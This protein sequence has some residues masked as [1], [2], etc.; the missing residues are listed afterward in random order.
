MV[1]FD[2]NTFF[3][4]EE[5]AENEIVE[6][7]VVDEDDENGTNLVRQAAQLL[8][9]DGDN[10]P[11]S[12]SVAGMEFESGEQFAALC[13][14]YA[15]KIEFQFQVRTSDIMDVYKEKGV[16]RNGV[17]ENEVQFHMMKRLRLICSRG[18]RCRANA[19]DPLCKV[20]VEGRIKFGV[21]KFVIMQ[22]QLE[23]NHEL[24]PSSSRHAVNYR[25]I[26][27]YF[28]RRMMLNDRAGIPITRNFNTIVMECGGYENIPFNDRD[29]K[30]A[31]NRERRKGRIGGD[32]QELINYFD[33]LKRD[34]A[35]FYF[36][37]QR[38]VNGALLNVF[39]ADARCRAMY[40]V[41]DDPVSYDTTFLSNRYRMP[42]SPFVGV[43]HH[44]CTIFFAAALVSYEDAET[45]E[46]VFERWVE[47]MGNAPNVFI[48]DQDKAM[49]VAIRKV[50]PETKHRLCLWHIL[51]NADKNLRNLPHFKSI[52]E[53]LRKMVHESLT[54]DEFQ[55]MWEQMVDK[56]SLQQNTWIKDAWHMRRR[57]V[58]VFWRG[59]FCAGM[60]STQRSEQSNR[61]IKSYVSVE[62]G[63]RQF[64]EQYEF[65]L[66]RKVEEE[67]KMNFNDKNKPLKWD[68]SILFEVVYHKEERRSFDVKIDTLIGDYACGC[69]KFEF[70]GIL[71]RHIMK[72]LA[73]LN[74][75]AIPDKY[76]LDRWRKDLVRGYENIRVG[77]YDP[78]ESERV[79]RSL[80][81]TMRN[82]YI[83]SLA[84]QDEEARAIYLEKTN[85]LIKSLE[86]HAGIETVDLF[87]E[88]AGS[89]RVWGHR[90]LQRKE[91]VGRPRQE[92]ADV[93]DP[94]DKRGNG[95]R[96]VP[97]QPKR[98]KESTTNAVPNPPLPHE[99]TSSQMS[100]FSTSQLRET[101]STPQM[102]GSQ[103][104][105]LL[106]TS[107]QTPQFS[108]SYFGHS[109]RMN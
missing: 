80:E 19:D 44:G 25:H 106:S 88:G 84:M 66:R 65:A 31:I 48:T 4:H 85:D 79:R 60:S 58:P 23:H 75:K 12:A 107:Q 101:Q 15:Y 47:C 78:I 33:T 30:N 3:D 37:Y 50:F 13:F 10:E 9:G 76:I 103:R 52:D 6:E 49:E 26:G 5:E 18:R 54:E 91:H 39:W 45:F 109:S 64:I 11:P 36:S 68:N 27:E 69:K 89:T 57:W 82:D 94:P 16:K 62:T 56:Y 28:K 2:L 20:L 92:D 67:N 108:S 104:T 90:R 7:N 21:D 32:A 102:S 97:R 24:D 96:R 83:V 59:I 61:F 43:N 70:E 72:C 74:V 77:Y 38:D 71:C 40:K 35:D 51:Q 98:R 95:R 8:D 87:V 14:M 73:V 100:G 99:D 42:F 29:M 17:D 41:F 1:S 93:R 34:N 63:L 46:W 81:L 86:E 22:C 55:M 53:D 105:L